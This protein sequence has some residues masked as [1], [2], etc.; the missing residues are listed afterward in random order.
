LAPVPIDEPSAAPDALAFMRATL[1]DPAY[2]LK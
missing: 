2:Q 1:L